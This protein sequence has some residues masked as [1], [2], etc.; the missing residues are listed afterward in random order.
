MAT[1]KNNFKKE[2][3]NIMIKTIDGSILSGKINIGLKQR[4]SEMFTQA[5]NPFIVLSDVED[6]GGLSKVLL[7]NKNHIVWVEP[8]D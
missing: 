6:K 5:D 8:K 2:Y 4:V 7:V 1:T 3:R